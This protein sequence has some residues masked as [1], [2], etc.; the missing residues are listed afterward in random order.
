MSFGDE[1]GR[2]GKEGDAPANLTTNPAT[3]K[4]TANVSLRG[5]GKEGVWMGKGRG[6]EGSREGRR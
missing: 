1:R 6:K 4:R 2:K 5:K 3:D